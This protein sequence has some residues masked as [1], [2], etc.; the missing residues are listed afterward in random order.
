MLGKFVLCFAIGTAVITG[1]SGV[2]GLI[3]KFIATRRGIDTSNVK[4]K[5][6]NPFK[7]D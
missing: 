2:L 5:I 1:V 3:A 7:R 6:A 4:F